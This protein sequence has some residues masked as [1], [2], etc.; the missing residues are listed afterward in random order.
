[1]PVKIQVKCSLYHIKNANNID[2]DE[3]ADHGPSDQDLC[4]L[5]IQLPHLYGY[6]MAFSPL[7]NDYK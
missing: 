6:K 7:Q 4:C 3:V 1:M 2:P 5:Q